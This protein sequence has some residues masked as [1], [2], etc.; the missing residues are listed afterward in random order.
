M[1]QL[2]VHRALDPRQTT[3]G[4][5]PAKADA[6][7][8]NGLTFPSLAEYIAELRHEALERQQAGAIQKSASD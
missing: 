1:G 7:P 6:Q 2:Q 5:P 8:S 4:T 3:G